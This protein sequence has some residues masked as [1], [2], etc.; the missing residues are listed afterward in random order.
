MLLGVRSEGAGSIRPD[1][2]AP[3]LNALYAA[4][5]AHYGAIADPAR[6]A[7]PNRKGTVESAVVTALECAAGVF[8]R[9]ESGSVTDLQERLSRLIGIEDS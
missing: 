5:L 2:Y 3:Q 1:L 6:V 7:D 4:L 9:D 8:G